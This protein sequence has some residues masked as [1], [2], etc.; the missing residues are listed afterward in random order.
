MNLTGLSFKPD[1]MT[2]SIYEC[3]VDDYPIQGSQIQTCV[4][5]LE[6]VGSR[7]DLAGAELE[8]VN[9]QNREKVF[10]HI[11]SFFYKKLLI[12][13][14]KELKRRYTILLQRV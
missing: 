3:L 4:N 13:L 2:S 7:I 8:L 10:V 11:F 12:F 5:G 1:D 6:L 14:D 9:K